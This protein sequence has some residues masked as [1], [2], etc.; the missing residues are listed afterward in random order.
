MGL[1]SDKQVLIPADQL[2]PRILTLRGQR[3]ILDSDLAAVYG[4]AT[5]TFNQAITRNAKRF[6][7]DFMF[8]L[9]ADEKREVI[10]NCDHLRHLKFSPY[11]PRAFTE[12][13]AVMAASVLNTPHAVEASI[14]V[15]RA[16][17]RLREVMQVQRALATQLKELERK[18]D[19]S[20]KTPPRMYG[21]DHM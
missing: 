16:F 12:H 10:T 9:T 3:V 18:V 8:T 19:S 7:L 11:L 1:Q 2:I 17:I 21:R 4:T 20:V 5:R 13:G 14:F 15:V 6:P